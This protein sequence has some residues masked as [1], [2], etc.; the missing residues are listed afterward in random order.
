[1]NKEARPYALLHNLRPESAV[2]VSAAGVCTAAQLL[3]DVERVCAAIGPG[4]GELL[5]V[6]ADRYRFAVG[7]LAAWRTGHSVGLPPN[8]QPEVSRHLVRDRRIAGALTEADD[9]ELPGRSIDLRPLVGGPPQRPA[10]VGGFLRLAP[11]RPLATVYTSGSTGDHQPCRKTTAQLVGEAMVLAEHF[12]ILPGA[13][14]LATVPPYHIYGLLF[15]VLVPLVAGAAF[16]LDAPFHAE[17]VAATLRARGAT[18]LVSVPAHLRSLT[19]LEPGSLPP[20]ARVFSSGAPLLESTGQELRERLGVTVTEVF[21]SSETGG[22]AWRLH[23]SADEPWTPLPGITIR[24][25][26]GGRLL[27]DSPFVDAALPRPYACEDRIELRPDGRF[28]LRGRLDGVVKIG[29]KRVAIAEL[30]RRLLDLPEV[31]DAA[32]VAVA[33]GGARGQKLVAAVAAASPVEDRGALA[34][35]I[36][37]ALLQWF[38]PVVVPRPIKIV[39][40]LPREASGKLTRRRLLDLF[41]PEDSRKGAREFEFRSHS[42][43][44][45]GAA[46]IH[47]FA[48]FVPTDLVYFRG[49]FDG[50]PVLPGVA[51]MLGVVLDRVSACAGEL[52]APR[53]LQKI[54]FRQQIRPGD[55]LRL[56]LEVDAE[57]RRVTFTL[58]RDGEPCT[59]GTVDYAGGP[60]PRAS[61]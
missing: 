6:C 34:G 19:V 57:A 55:A 42:V 13:R 30:E 49:H 48:V 15:G 16:L 22:I 29:G 20:L 8:L 61:Q 54:K 31:A 43:R 38:D 4:E 52:G 60:R 37:A 17:A 11:D 12:G 41:E 32:V 51:Q 35:R 9:L 14:V 1:M 2:C 5:L 59:T 45:R 23:T 40:A 7:L 44:T 26:S 53:R 58:S 3:A 25:D 50:H 46:R 10:D 56:C 24:V 36:R 47:E 28:A 18:V 33:V 39:D 27:L 21:G